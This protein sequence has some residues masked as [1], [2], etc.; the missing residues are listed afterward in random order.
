METKG[1]EEE[2]PAEDESQDSLLRLDSVFF[3]PDFMGLSIQGLVQMIQDGDNSA[4]DEIYA[5][6]EH[7][8]LHDAEIFKNKYGYLEDD[9]SAFF[10]LLYQATEKAIK[11][12]SASKGLFFH[13]W[14]TIVKRDKIHLLRQLSLEGRPNQKNTI[15]AAKDDNPEFFDVL[16]QEQS[17][18]LY[19]EA[20]EKRE[21][22]ILKENGEKVLL[23]VKRHY[24]PKDVKMLE[25][26]MQSY[27]LEEISSL[28][29]MP[30]KKLLGRLYTIL[31]SLRKNMDLSELDQGLEFL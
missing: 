15:Y 31:E 1:N 18:T 22:A 7:E 30:M 2:P 25:Y 27:S 5:R 23:F 3:N 8:F 10:E 14:R 12:F 11:T 20:E 29:K 9:E 4:R 26:W 19:D 6:F 28:A 17:F 21:Q 24:T 13:Y 16:I